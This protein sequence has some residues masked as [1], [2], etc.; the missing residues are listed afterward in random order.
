MT[1]EWTEIYY[2]LS[3]FTTIY[4]LFYY[5]SDFITFYYFLLLYY[6]VDTL[7]DA[8]VHLKKHCHISSTLLYTHAKHKLRLLDRCRCKI[9]LKINFLQSQQSLFSIY[10]L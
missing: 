9:L 5:L 3:N 1:S 4:Y 10:D 8:M 7:N 2:L 6:L